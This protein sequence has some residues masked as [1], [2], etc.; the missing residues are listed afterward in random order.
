MPLYGML[1]SQINLRRVNT[2]RVIT[3]AY[4]LLF[5]GSMLVSGIF[6]W[7]TRQ[8]YVRLRDE[9]VAARAQVAEL[10]KKLQQQEEVLERL[11]TDPAYVE[12]V[13]R[14]RLRLAKP[15]E[16]VFRFEDLAR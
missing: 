14:K 5:V 12:R 15:D 8:E 7:Q 2:Q 16:F 10:T 11:R 9:E 13:I 6:F 3:G 1:P 4:L